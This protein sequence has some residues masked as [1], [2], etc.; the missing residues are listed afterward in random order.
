MDDLRI[1]GLCTGSTAVVLDTT[2]ELTASR[3][4]TA[5]SPMAVLW[6]IPMVGFIYLDPTSSTLENGT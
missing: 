1:D 2:D 5:I 4:H 6:L 3:R